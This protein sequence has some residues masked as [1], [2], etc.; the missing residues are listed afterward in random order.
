M[1]DNCTWNARKKAGVFC[2]VDSGQGSSNPV[3][4]LRRRFLRSMPAVLLAGAGGSAA[5]LPNRR[6]GL[7]IHSYSQRW[8]GRYSNVRMPPFKDALDVLDH[9]RALGIGGLQ[10]GQDGWTR[11]LARD[12]KNTC[13]SYDM[14]LEGMVRLP[15]AE[16]DVERFSR[17]LRLG[18]E[19]GATIFRTS[20]GGRRYE[21]FHSRADYEMWFSLAARSL[22]RAE[23]VARRLKVKLA[24]EN[25]KD[26]EVTELVQLMQKL[27]SPHVG[28]CLD[29]GNSLA[30]LESPLEVVVA[31]APYTFTVHLKDI[32]VAEAE[33]GFL[34]AE[35]PLGKGALPLGSMLEVLRREAPHADFYLEMITREPLLI[36]CLGEGYWATFPEKSGRD[37]VKALTWVREHQKSM[38]PGVDSL[39]LEARLALEERNITESLTQ[40]ALALNFPQTQVMKALSEEER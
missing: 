22:E 7:V 25:H 1:I 34:M 23:V 20:L 6:L 32:A 14:R 15:Q 40:A 8:Q 35:V 9:A 28:V 4:M 5:S 3:F 37:L 12:V 26:L 21:L 31:L 18:M 29:T 27:S 38:L 11:E 39:S 36:P 16:G 19:A 17:D 30:L 13:E 24:V 33:K 10:I 2:V